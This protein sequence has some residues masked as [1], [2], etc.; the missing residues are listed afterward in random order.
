MNFD[1]DIG[2]YLQQIHLY[3]S[4]D[5]G[6][7]PW[8]EC[9]W[10]CCGKHCPYAPD[11]AQF[12]C[13][14]FQF[15]VS[16]FFSQPLVSSGPLEPP[17]LD[18]LLWVPDK[19]HAEKP[20]GLCVITE[21]AA[22]VEKSAKGIS[23]HLASLCLALSSQTQPPNHNTKRL[24]DSQLSVLQFTITQHYDI[25]FFMAKLAFLHFKGVLPPQLLP[26]EEKKSAGFTGIFQS[27]SSASPGQYRNMYWHDFFLIDSEV[28]LNLNN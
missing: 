20:P 22:P 13:E 23:Q 6:H 15:G 1:E 2:I 14:E 24:M 16:P 28:F 17:V 21:P 7:W 26:H 10:V 9:S 25:M 19:E 8:N 18:L 3:N 11:Q 5:N 12:A 27:W 4:M